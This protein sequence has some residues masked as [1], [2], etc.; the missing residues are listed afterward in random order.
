MRGMQVQLNPTPD[1]DT[2]AAILAAIACCLQPNLVGD[3]IASSPCS[4]WRAAGI[5]V[6]QGL[7]PARGAKRAVRWSSGIVG[8]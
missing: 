3:D 2:A 5:L 4:A 7:P 6:A 8:M 1:D